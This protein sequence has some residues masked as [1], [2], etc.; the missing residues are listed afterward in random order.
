MDPPDI[1]EAVIYIRWPCQR[2]SGFAVGWF[3]VENERRTLYELVYIAVLT[4][5]NQRRQIAPPAAVRWEKNKSNILLFFS[6]SGGF[7][8]ANIF[9]KNFWIRVPIGIGLQLESLVTRE[10]ASNKS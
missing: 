7:F 5:S 10:T 2:P 3:Y 4:I 8:K 9:E 6:H 1:F